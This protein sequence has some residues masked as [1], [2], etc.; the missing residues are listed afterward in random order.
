[1]KALTVALCAGFVL[2]VS[3]PAARAQDWFGAATWQVSFPTSDTKN[4]VDAVSF[5]GVGLDF[6]KVVRPAT[7]AGLALGW[8]V[9]HQRVTG[10]YEIK[11]GAV[12]GTQDRYINSFP[13]M[14]GVHRYFGERGGPRPY[15][16]LNAGAMVIIRTFAVGVFSTEE[17]SWDWGVA[18]EVGVI[19]PTQTGAALMINGRYNWSFTHQNLLDQDEDL[20]Y[21]GINVGFVWEQY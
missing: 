3:S 13:I 6:R 16:G 10:T 21:W 5:R 12:T 8:N 4:F 2:L 20:T 15:V 14:A 9:F 18:P 11:N 7:T 1:M 19:I 17:D